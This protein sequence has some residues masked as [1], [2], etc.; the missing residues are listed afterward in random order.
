[1]ASGQ[2]SVNGNVAIGDGRDQR[3]ENPQ[4]SWMNRTIVAMLK[5]YVSNNGK[6]WDIKL[7]LV[8]MA[9]RST[10]NALQE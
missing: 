9:I 5:K 10:P 2:R 6:D 8:L 3:T 7:P 1:G 4:F